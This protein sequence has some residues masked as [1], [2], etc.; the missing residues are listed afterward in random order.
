MHAL[1]LR[2]ILPALAMGLALG[3]GPGAESPA[4][5]PA[6][7]RGTLESSRAV[8]LYLDL[9]KATLTDLV[10]ENE[11][12]MRARLA[13]E[14]TFF[15]D[16]KRGIQY[17]Y[18]DR[19]HTMI[20]LSRLENIRTLVEDVIAG[21]VPGDLLEAGAWRGGATIF[22]R[23]VLA[24]HGETDRTVWVADSFE[25]L[26]PPNPDEFPADKGLDLHEID[27]L[28]ISLEEAQRNFERYGL[29]DDQVRFLKG[30]FK[31]TL[32][33]APIEQLA[34]LRLDA[35]LYESTMD[36]IVPLYSKVTPGGYVIV[37]DYKLIPACRKA[38]D[39]FRAQNGITE[40]LVDIDWN[41]V[42]WQKR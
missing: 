16:L 22:M 7:R 2:R 29:L 12:K 20:G 6:E 25:G 17:G 42:Y 30:W 19:A 33:D 15:E 11:P 4:P 18:P 38:I 32:P 21:G 28:A 10:Y 5:D 31:D 27:E 9:M 3:C 36:A 14:P 26:P 34:I 13:A 37:D 1:R 23:A 40:P 41:A 39:D 35:D 24:A 8:D